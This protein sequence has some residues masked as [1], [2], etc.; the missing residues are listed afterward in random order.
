MGG[1]RRLGAHHRPWFH[2]HNDWLLTPPLGLATVVHMFESDPE[3]GPITAAE[4]RVFTARLAAVDAA[5]LLGSEAGALC[6]SLATLEHATAAATTRLAARVDEVGT[7]KGDGARS[8]DAWLAAARGC[9]EGAARAALR[10][11]A[12]LTELPQVAALADAG[13]LSPA[14]VELV[15]IGASADAGA[16]DELLSLCRSGTLR[17]LRDRAATAAAS[18][19]RAK[20]RS[21]DAARNRR[22][23]FST[24]PLTGERR[25]TGSHAAEHMAIIEARLRADAERQ[26][27]RGRREGRRLPQAA[28]MMDALLA[29]CGGSPDALADDLDP[30][31]DAGNDPH[32]RADPPADPPPPSSG[33]A[34]GA[35]PAS[36]PGSAPAASPAPQPAPQP[37]TPPKAQVLIHIDLD[38][39]LRGH[40]RS[41]ERCEIEGVGDI[42][43]EAAL[44]FADDAFIKAV[45]REGTDIRTVCHLGRGIPAILRT[46]IEARSR[47]CDRPGCDSTAG[48]QI[49]HAHIDCADDGPLTLDGGHRLCPHDHRKKTHEGYRLLG[50]HGNL[51]WVDADGRVVTADN[52]DTHPP[53]PDL[54]TAQATLRKNL[55]SRAPTSKRKKQQKSKQ[56]RR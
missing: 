2:N 56:K 44:R 33:G 52:P 10:T 3:A 45:I 24:D 17:Q 35:A 8:A 53:I 19:G 29:L 28:R 1:G 23:S 6:R 31:A 11:R 47:C 14:Q 38:A 48:L 9:S 32:P 15:A 49:D 16:T 50:T 36:A 39:L 22:L 54:L 42:P 30:D 13:A 25:M 51:V 4:I 26:F 41:G 18:N 34:T 5:E 7:W 27:H 46:A 40:T 37:A 20:K 21:R 43:V 12:K 55:R